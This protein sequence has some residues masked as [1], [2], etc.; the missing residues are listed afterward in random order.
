MVLQISFQ[1]SFVLLE[2]F[3]LIIVNDDER[4]VSKLVLDRRVRP[5]GIFYVILFCNCPTRIP[6]N[7][8]ILWTRAADFHFC[9][10]YLTLQFTFFVSRQTVTN[11]WCDTLCV[12]GTAL[13]TMWLTGEA[14]SLVWRRL[15]VAIIAFP[16]AWSCTTTVLDRFPIAKG[17]AWT[18]QVGVA[19]IAPTKFVRNASAMSWTIPSTLWTNFFF[20]KRH[21]LLITYI[22]LGI[23]RYSLI[24]VILL[25]YRKYYQSLYK[26]IYSH[27]QQFIV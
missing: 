16:F 9:T 12:Y 2:K 13:A 5:H 17:L 25:N 27:R 10:G 18:G 11:I 22:F 15:E 21:L 6:L 26:A 1:R 3:N 19:L 7:L 8:V 24:I 23:L 4:S 20:W 14:M